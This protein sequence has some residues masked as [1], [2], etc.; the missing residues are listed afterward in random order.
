MKLTPTFTSGKIKMMFPIV[1]KCGQEMQ[2]VTE[3]SA[4]IGD[5]IEIKDLTSRFATDAISSCAFGI[6]ANSLKN[7]DSTIRAMGRKIFEPNWLTVLRNFVAFFA[8]DIGKLFKVCIQWM[9]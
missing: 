5:V 3:E 4:K 7:P 8:P 1:A 2:E 9:L 6:E